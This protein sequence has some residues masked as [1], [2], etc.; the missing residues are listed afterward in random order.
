MLTTN[1][2]KMSLQEKKLAIHIKIENFYRQLHCGELD[3]MQK[4]LAALQKLSEESKAIAT[5]KES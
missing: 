2:T 1:F 3:E 4:L 5:Q